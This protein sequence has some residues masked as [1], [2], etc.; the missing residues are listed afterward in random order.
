MHAD[1]I[2]A[3]AEHL[4]NQI[5]LTGERNNVHVRATMRGLKSMQA[6]GL[7]P[8]PGMVKSLVDGATVPGA[9]E[10]EEI[11]EALRL[12]ADRR[13]T[14]GASLGKGAV[15]HTGVTEDLAA[16]ARRA[17]VRLRSSKDAWDFQSLCNTLGIEL[18]APS[19]PSEASGWKGVTKSTLAN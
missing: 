3:L 7:R 9:L 2:K 12:L 5:S 6:M 17:A 4:C 8:P 14:A 11:L 16:A 19:A 13:I 10:P 18:Q 15:I 1:G